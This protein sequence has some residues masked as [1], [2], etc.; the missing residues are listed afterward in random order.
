MNVKWSPGMGETR[1]PGSAGATPG[2]QSAQ[3]DQPQVTDAA[4]L[5]LRRLAA[6]L[7]AQTDELA[8]LRRDV[9]AL[10]RDV[11]ALRPPAQTWPADKLEDLFRHVWRLHGTS[12][13][14][15]RDLHA[16]EL[17]ADGEPR[18]LGYVLARLR[19]RG[20]RLGVW[21]LRSL[22]SGN[23]T[24]AGQLWRLSVEGDDAPLSPPVALS[25]HPGTLTTTEARDA[26]EDLEPDRNDCRGALDRRR[27]S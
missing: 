22:T 1:R 9:A 27:R 6:A 11:A 14:T 10:R 12:C 21:Q 17:L 4:L 16:A 8:A 24:N 19:D 13:W 7:E 18:P 25:D 5:E 3:R 20:G 26:Q 23:K 15:V 2:A